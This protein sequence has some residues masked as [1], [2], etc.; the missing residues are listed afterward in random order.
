MQFP[1]KQHQNATQT[2][3]Y[4]EIERELNK[5]DLQQQLDGIAIYSFSYHCHHKP[6][7]PAFHQSTHPFIAALVICCSSNI[8]NTQR[9]QPEQQGSKIMFTTSTVS[10]AAEHRTEPDRDWNGWLLACLG[11]L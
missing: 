8:N 3:T 9:E 11:R 1:S 10:A 6:M 2:I 4:G 7:E 5:L